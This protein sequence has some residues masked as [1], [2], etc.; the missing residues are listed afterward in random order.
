M[1]GI[2][3][4]GIVPT[5][6][7]TSVL[8][9]P[10][11]NVTLS[12]RELA[13]LMGFT[14]SSC[15]WGTLGERS[16]L[17]RLGNT[18]HVAVVGLVLVCALASIKK[19]SGH[20]A[21]VA[22]DRTTLWLSTHDDA[23][24]LPRAWVYFL[25]QL[26]RAGIAGACVSV[27]TDCSGIEAP[28][29]ALLY[30]QRLAKVQGLVWCLRHVFACDCNSGCERYIREFTKPEL[31]FSDALRRNWGG[32][33]CYCRDEITGRSVRV[34]VDLDVYIAGFE[35]KPFSLRHHNSTCFD[36]PHAAVFFACKQ[37]IERARP[38]VAILE[39]VNGLLRFGPVREQRCI[40]IVLGELQ[41]IPGYVLDYCELDPTDY[42]Y[43]IARPRFFFVLCSTSECR[44]VDLSALRQFKM[45]TDKTWR[46]FLGM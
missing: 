2:R 32:S 33:V 9:S 36:D 4:D 39:N 42:G 44:G 19:W 34:P 38:K 18:M 37:Y 17:E 25:P 11:L 6:T 10:A 7:T 41:S 40:D 29:V 26:R 5:L 20:E 22:E 13:P 16:W 28:V 12:S 31:F 1:N 15:V 24:V 45:P 35:C 23:D 43:P 8:Y 14:F 46:T 30:I 27:G 3:H 21:A